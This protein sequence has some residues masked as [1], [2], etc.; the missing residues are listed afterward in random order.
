M[1]ALKRCELDDLIFIDIETVRGH[2]DLPSAP[3]V[4]QSAWNYKL[5][6]SPEKLEGMQPET[7]YRDKAALY[8]EFGKIVCV[9][10]GKISK[11]GSL[12]MSSC[13]EGQELR[14]GSTVDS[15]KKLLENTN[16]WISHFA[17]GRS[18]MLIGHAIKGFDIPYLF[19]RSLINRVVPHE[20][21][22]TSML[23]PWEMNALDTL[24]L[25][26][27]TG[28]YSAS[29]LSIAACFDLP[30]PK[31]D[32]EGSET[33][34]VYYSDADDSVIRIK[35]YCERDVKTVVNIVRSIR[36]EPIYE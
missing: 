19:R 21:F 30:S 12:I 20:L 6:Y 1:K 16:K 5:R 10:L 29:L 36:Q 2:R 3:P 13:Y 11:D 9:S 15:E 24:E 25:W 35:D 31:I 28:F 26:K 32:I 22:D 34:E 23:K 8:P 14:D 4:I 17:N 27:G 7:S 33:S 18:V